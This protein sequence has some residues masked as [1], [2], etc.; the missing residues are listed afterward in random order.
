MMKSA[1]LFLAFL[2]VCS[3]PATAG[4]FA[5]HVDFSAGKYPSGVATGDFNHDG[6]PDLAV[7][8]Q[9]GSTVSVLI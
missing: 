7:S 8:D 2:V 3:L 9:Q 5:T 6:K 4:T 1:G